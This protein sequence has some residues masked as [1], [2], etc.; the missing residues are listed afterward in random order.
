MAAL[1]LTLAPSVA[2]I[3]PTTRVVASGLNNPRGITV[4]SSGRVLVAESGSGK[5]LAIKGG[6]ITTL[7]SGLPSLTSPEG[8][9]TGVVNVAVRNGTVTV[10]IGG[11]PQSVDRALRH[12]PPPA[13]ARHHQDRRPAAVSGT[14]T[15]T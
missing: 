11:G 7:A 2:A 14:A 8:E 5:V 4:S 12:D 15:P 6:Q 9:T 1:C 3:S 13:L 10:A